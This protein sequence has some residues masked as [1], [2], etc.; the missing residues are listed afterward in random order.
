MYL[1]AL[2]SASVPRGS[3]EAAARCYYG[4]CQVDS[5]LANL[6]KQLIQEKESWKGWN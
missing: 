5:K 3:V 4:Y 2:Y 6:K 1:L